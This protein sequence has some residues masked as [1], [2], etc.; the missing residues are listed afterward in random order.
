V[1]VAGTMSSI[2]LSVRIWHSS[3]TSTPTRAK[4]RPNPRSRAPNNT[5]DPFRNTIDSSPA[6]ETTRSTRGAIDFRP[7][8]DFIDPNVSR[9][10]LNRCAVHNTVKP[11]S[12]RHNA[13][14]IDPI[15]YVFPT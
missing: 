8:I 7:A 10:V 6:P 12:I 3:I 4:P 5:R 14:Q 11:G 15:R 9:A 1:F 13:K 2:A